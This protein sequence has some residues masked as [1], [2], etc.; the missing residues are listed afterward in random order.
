[1][2]ED[3]KCKIQVFDILLVKCI[4]NND[5]SVLSVISRWPAMM[6]SL[7]GKFMF[8]VGKFNRL[9]S[10]RNANGRYWHLRAHAQQQ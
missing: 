9:L 1:M 8:I 3:A 10:I 4:N 5:D 2:H 6:I 7:Y